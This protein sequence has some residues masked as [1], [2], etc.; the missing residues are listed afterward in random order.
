MHDLNDFMTE[1]DEKA[2]AFNKMIEEFDKIA[3][4][5]AVTA[6]KCVH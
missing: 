5:E 2:A 3:I 4:D 1:Q 6:L